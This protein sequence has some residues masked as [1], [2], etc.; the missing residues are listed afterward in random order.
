[1]ISLEP[2]H[3]IVL[4][5]VIRDSLYNTGYLVLQVGIS[6]LSQ[7]NGEQ[8]VVSVPRRQMEHR[9]SADVRHIQMATPVHEHLRSLQVGALH[10]PGSKYPFG[11]VTNELDQAPNLCRGVAPSASLACTLAP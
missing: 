5:A 6:S 4:P 10:S 9:V 11:N 3:A 1:M 8:L 7:E 2:F